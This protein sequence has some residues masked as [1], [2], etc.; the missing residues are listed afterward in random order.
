MYLHVPK[1]EFG[2][3]VAVLLEQWLCTRQCSCEIGL[4]VSGKGVGCRWRV[5]LQVVTG[6]L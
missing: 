6:K 5:L 2:V 4:S 1:Y 3:L